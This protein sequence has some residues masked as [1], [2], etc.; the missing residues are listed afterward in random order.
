MVR[1]QSEAK[2]FFIQKVVDQAGREGAALSKAER[3]MLT[4][5]EGDPEFKFDQVLVDQLAAEI[6][7][8]DYESKVA[9]LLARALEVESAAD[10]GARDV[11]LQARSDLEE[12]DHYIAIMIESAFKGTP[13]P[14]RWWEVWR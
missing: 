13:P 2:R 3:W 10:P 4:W 5:S 9:G 6:S 14:K 11:W 7:D 12:G 8:E 1:S